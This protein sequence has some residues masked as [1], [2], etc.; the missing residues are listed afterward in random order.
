MLVFKNLFKD[1]CYWR[2]KTNR[3]V[4]HSAAKGAFKRKEER[5]KV[6]WI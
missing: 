4:L 2:I 5:M 3:A 1:F 6:S